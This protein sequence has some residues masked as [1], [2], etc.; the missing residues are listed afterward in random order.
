MTKSA[1]GQLNVKQHIGI[2]RE[3][4]DSFK[5]L[6]REFIIN[7]EAAKQLSLCLLKEILLFTGRYVGDEQ[8]K[9]IPL[10]AIEYIHSHFSCIYL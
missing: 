3:L 8:K 5:K 6:F 9:G 7:D 1:L 4:I 2:H 10:L